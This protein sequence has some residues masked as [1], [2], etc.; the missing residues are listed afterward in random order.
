V[1]GRVAA[2]DIAAGTVVTGAY[3]VQLSRLQMESRL[4]NFWRRCK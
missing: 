2:V 3:L 4:R 1:I